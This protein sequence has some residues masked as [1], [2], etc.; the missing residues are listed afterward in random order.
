MRDASSKLSKGR[1]FLRMQQTCL[2]RLQL[3]QGFFGGIPRGA[4]FRFRPLAFSDVAVDQHKAAAGYGIAARFDHLSVRSRARK[5]RWAVEVAKTPIQFLLDT[6]EG[7]EFATLGEHPNV[8]N[9]REALAQ[10]R[11]G[12]IE[13]VLK[14]AVPGN[15]P[16]F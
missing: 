10:Q 7:A 1:H 15:E 3:A 9:I 5:Q 12:Q 13:N 2:R 14:V 4:D 11:I 6:I 8:L 16:W